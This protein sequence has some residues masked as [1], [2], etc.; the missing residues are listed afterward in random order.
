MT[1]L[2][3]SNFGLAMSA[4]GLVCVFSPRR[5]SRALGITSAAINSH[6][7]GWEPVGRLINQM[8]FSVSLW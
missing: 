8:P 5:P 7:L 3:V 6:S 1:R 4:I 2:D